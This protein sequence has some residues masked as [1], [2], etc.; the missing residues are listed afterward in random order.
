MAIKTKFK[1]NDEVKVLSGFYEGAI[2][3]VIEV[4]TGKNWNF[5]TVDFE[6]VRTQII[7]TQLE[8]VWAN[9]NITPKK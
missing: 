6:V 3:K 8:L 4:W 2:G 7:E 5:Y 9:P 1:F